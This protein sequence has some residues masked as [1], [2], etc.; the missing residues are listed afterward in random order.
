MVSCNYFDLKT[1]K[2]SNGFKTSYLLAVLWFQI[3]L[4]NANNFKQ[5]YLTY[6]RDAKQF[7]IF[8]VRVDVGVMAMKALFHSSQRSRKGTLPP[9][10]V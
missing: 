4:S 3:Y 7:L 9:D 5:M 8:R 1:V 6:S 2:P 10:G